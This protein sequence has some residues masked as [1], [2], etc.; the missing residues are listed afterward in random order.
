M[1]NWA[2]KDLIKKIFQ[3]KRDYNNRRK[4]KNKEQR[5]HQRQH[6][7]NQQEK[8]QYQ[9][10]QQKQ[11]GQQEHHQNQQE[12]HQHQQ[13]QHQY[14]YED[15]GKYLFKFIYIL[16]LLESELDIMIFNIMNFTLNQFFKILTLYLNI[17]ISNL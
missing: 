16:L 1:S 8:H 12:K 7:Q 13:E 10:R 11:Q 17:F 6:H 5:Q 4:N 14:S 2:V 9:Q 3:H 15:S